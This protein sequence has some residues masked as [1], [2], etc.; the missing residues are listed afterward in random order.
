MRAIVGD[1]Q[2]SR[3]DRGRSFIDLNSRFENPRS[4]IMVLVGKD[5]VLHFLCLSIIAV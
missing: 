2:G 5:L 3:Q 1:L 4:I